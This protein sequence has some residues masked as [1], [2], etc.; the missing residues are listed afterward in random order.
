MQLREVDNVF[1]SGFTSQSDETQL[2]F[3]NPLGRVCYQKRTLDAAE[4]LAQTRRIVEVRFDEFQGAIGRRIH[5]FFFPVNHG[6]NPLSS[7]GQTL[8][9]FRPVL[10]RGSGN[11]YHVLLLPF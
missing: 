7:A 5:D 2:T 3:L 9:D 10:S 1:H 6:P 11:K 4:G 8:E